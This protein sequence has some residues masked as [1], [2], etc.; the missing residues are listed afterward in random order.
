MVLFM[1]RA[2]CSPRVSIYTCTTWKSPARHWQSCR[3][4]FLSCTPILTS[5]SPTA[6]CFRRHAARPPCCTPLGRGHSPLCQ[7]PLQHW[8]GEEGCI[9]RYPWPI[10]AKNRHSWMH[11]ESNTAAS[12]ETSV[13]D[14]ALFLQMAN[15]CLKRKKKKNSLVWVFPPGA[16][17]RASQEAPKERQPTIRRL[18]LDLQRARLPAGTL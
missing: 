14:L 8:N 2:S 6:V 10:I 5:F 18:K 4:C 11:C 15:F 12:Q 16:C 17:L 3:N 13:S 7:L 1:P 9:S